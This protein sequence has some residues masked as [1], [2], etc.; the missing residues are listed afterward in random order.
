MTGSCGSCL[1][2]YATFRKGQLGWSANMQGKG[3]LKRVS[4]DLFQNDCVGGKSDPLTQQHWS[5]WWSQLVRLGCFLSVSKFLQWLVLLENI[6]E[7]I[8]GTVSPEKLYGATG[9]TVWGVFLMGALAP[10]RIQCC[11]RQISL[12]LLV[13]LLI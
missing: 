9:N 2:L 3:S 4:G 12:L 7:K 5:Q 13:L 11:F 6:S 8:L 10:R 1:M